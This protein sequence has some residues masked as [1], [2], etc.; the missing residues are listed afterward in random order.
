MP[1]RAIRKKTIKRAIFPAIVEIFFNYNAYLWFLNKTLDHE[2]IMYL[3]SFFCCLHGVGASQK[4]AEI[5][6]AYVKKLA[7]EEKSNNVALLERPR[8]FSSAPL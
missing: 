3:L 1:S 6:E 8:R 4:N 2:K 7:R 5:D